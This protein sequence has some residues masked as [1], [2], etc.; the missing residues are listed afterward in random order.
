[1]AGANG[2]FLALLLVLAAGVAAVAPGGTVLRALEVAGGLFLLWVATDAAR[3]AWRGRDLERAE[4]DA[5][6][7]ARASATGGQGR[8]AVLARPAVRGTLAVLLNPGAWLFLATSAT[9]LVADSTAAGGRATA[10][11][12]VAALLVGVS[13]MDALTV[14]V[15]GSLLKG[16]AGRW[17]RLGLTVALGAIGLLFLV[18]GAA[19]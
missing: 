11:L 3:E 13:V 6:A 9:A 17:V 7:A 8:A 16:A 10:L 4:A 14:L 2:T 19:G 15:G 18:R 5:E 12:T 1:M